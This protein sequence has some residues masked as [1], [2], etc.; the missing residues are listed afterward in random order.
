[1]LL[2]RRNEEGG[3]RAREARPNRRLSR[4][5]AGFD[6]A[7]DS[8]RAQPGFDLAEMHEQSISRRLDPL[9]HLTSLA[10]FD[11]GSRAA[12]EH[13]PERTGRRLEFAGG[14]FRRVEL[15]ARTRRVVGEI[16]LDERS[17]SSAVRCI[18]E[19]LKNDLLS[20]TAIRRS[21]WSVRERLRTQVVRCE[22]RQRDD[23]QSDPTCSTASLRA[24]EPRRRSG[25]PLR[26]HSL[27]RF[28]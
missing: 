26:T 27:L 7:S 10:V 16:P 24:L 22:N 21:A 25:L 3:V 23:G 12:R 6:L 2:D 14:R 4:S 20:R 28:E 1:M 18:R 5:A 11:S 8:S 17:R 15:L 19:G 13:R 9:E